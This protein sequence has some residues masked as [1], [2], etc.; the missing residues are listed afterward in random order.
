MKDIGPVVQSVHLD[1]HAENKDITAPIVKTSLTMT[2]IDAPDHV[3]AYYKKCGNWEEFYTA[4]SKKWKV[5]IQQRG[6]IIWQGYITPNS[7]QEEL[8]YRGS[9]TIVAR[10]GLGLLNEL[11][12]DAVGDKLG[13][14]SV[15]DLITEGWSKVESSMIL[16]WGGGYSDAWLYCDGTPAYDTYV[17]VAAF[18]GK[19]WYEAIESILDSYALC[20]RYIGDARIA[21]VSLRF[22]PYLRKLSANG[23][24]EY[25]TP[26]FITGAT[27]E[28]V[29]AV[30]EINETVDYDIEEVY[31]PLR[32]S[33]EF[34]GETSTYDFTPKL[35][36]VGVMSIPAPVHY[37]K[38][39]LYGW[40]AIN[41]KTLMFNPE[42]YGSAW[43][44]QSF[45]V[46]PNAILFGMDGA[47]N[48]HGIWFDLPIY[49]YDINVVIE[50]GPKIGLYPDIFPSKL[51]PATPSDQPSKL[52]YWLYVRAGGQDYWYNGKEWQTSYKTLTAS[53]QGGRTDIYIPLSQ[54]SGV[55]D[56]RIGIEDMITHDATT[57]TL[58]GLYAS[59]NRIAVKKGEN[60]SLLSTNRVNTIYNSSNR[61][62][63]NRKVDFGPAYNDVAIPGF[64]KNGIFTYDGEMYAPAKEWSWPAGGSNQQMAVYNHLSIIPYFARPHNL[65]RGT[66]VNRGANVV[67]P[68]IT[69]EWGGAYHIMKSGSFDLITGRINRAELQSYDTYDA[70]WGRAS[71]SLPSIGSSSEN[72]GSGDNTSGSGSSGGSSGSGDSTGGG[73][74][75][76]T[77][78]TE[79][80]DTSTNAVQNMVIKKY[81]DSELSDLDTR[82]TGKLDNVK[83]T[84]NDLD[85]RL[86]G[87]VNDLATTVGG[88]KG[89]RSAGPRVKLIY[90]SQA[91]DYSYK[92]DHPWLIDS[93]LNAEVCLMH[94][95][96]N[97]CRKAG[98][99]MHLRSKAWR[100][101]AGRGQRLIITDR[102]IELMAVR[103]Y[104]TS[105]WL[106]LS[107]DG[108]TYIPDATMLNI[109]Y[110][111]LR[112]RQWAFAEFRNV[113]TNSKLFGWAVRYPNPEFA[114]YITD[115][116]DDD[117]TNVLDIPRW[118]YSEVTP[119][120]VFVHKDAQSLT[121][122]GTR[123][124]E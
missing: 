110:S 64:I 71:S 90:H 21:I 28:L 46:S 57:Q 80:S 33:I 93:S 50:W 18:K 78:D 56:L 86:T 65:L 17:N 29:S 59:I 109:G 77:I 60:T 116:I 27:R 61:V 85:T 121:A 96:K 112:S 118:I 73:T 66:I 54:L 49:P 70:L 107:N 95:N 117:T 24:L 122:I 3:E 62:L 26:T 44:P 102:I 76:I 79:M 5:D 2:F 115:N 88:L 51:Y 72:S 69:W 23:A 42:V 94:Y 11:Q 6:D 35:S 75:T 74:T 68:C 84:V 91:D 53:D 124:T 30:K 119:M 105:S 25:A 9:V 113:G 34:T 89:A 123:L 20:L 38:T 58:E 16:L 7:Y 4:D 15:Y 83:T 40:D 63:I 32:E 108:N 101:A 81:V 13:M 104:I 47:D 97:A 31:L 99:R 106:K 82:L 100:L 10:D 111:Y 120:R 67:D 92:F 48:E 19:T 114:R 37:I 14:I 36:G 8:R 87:T 12:F 98:T 41:S 22:M 52:V 39:S 43:K 1:I 45:G 103:D 55:V